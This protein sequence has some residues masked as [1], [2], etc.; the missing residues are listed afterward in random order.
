MQGRAVEVLVDLAPVVDPHGTGRRDG[1]L[2]FGDLRGSLWVGHGL[3]TSLS[4]VLRCQDWAAAMM[5]SAASRPSRSARLGSQDA[6]VV[7]RHDLGEAGDRGGEVGKQALRHRGAGLG[8]V[9]GEHLFQ[10]GAVGVVERVDVHHLGVDTPLVQVEDVGDAAGHAGREVASGRS[11]DDGAAP[12]HVLAAVVADPFDHGVRP[13][14]ADAEPFADDAAEEQ[15]AGGGAVGDDVAGDDV[16]FGGER[17]AVGG[18]T[19]IRAAGQALADV[20]VG[21]A[22]KRAA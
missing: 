2:P 10:A 17:G 22:D 12:G 6:L 11:E 13:G 8:V 18:R 7:A 19:M 4:R 14:V 15:F 9:A 21:V 3:S 1:Q 16:L 5:A 20:V